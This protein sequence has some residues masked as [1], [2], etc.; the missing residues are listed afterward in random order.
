[1][2]SSRP[3]GQALIDPFHSHAKDE[4]T[5]ADI[6]AIISSCVEWK[7]EVELKRETGIPTRRMR[8]ALAHAVDRNSLTVCIRQSKNKAWSRRVY[9]QTALAKGADEQ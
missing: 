6:A 9:I 3:Y 5:E 1:V 4:H 7:G 8:T 2:K